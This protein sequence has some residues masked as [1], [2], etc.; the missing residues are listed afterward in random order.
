MPLSLIASYRPVAPD[1][2]LMRSANLEQEVAMFGPKNT[3]SFSLAEKIQL[4]PAI[5]E[6]CVER[7]FASVLT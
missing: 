2:T 5:F 3:S 1:I 7:R 6:S 4:S